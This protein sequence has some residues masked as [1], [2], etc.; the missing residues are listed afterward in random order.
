MPSNIRKIPALVIKNRLAILLIISVASPVFADSPQPAPAKVTV[1]SSTK[2]LCVLSD[3]ASNTTVVSQ[4]VPKGRTW[5]ISGWHRWLFVSDDGESVVIGYGGMNLV[6]IDVTLQEPVLLFYNRGKFM[7]SVTLGDLYTSKS[8]L[9]RTVSH[10]VWAQSL[11]FNKS[12]QLVVELVNG[13]KVAFAAK[14]GMAQ[15]LIRDVGNGT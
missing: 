11:G 10:F 13:K 9:Q 6:P 15:P 14:N 2:N 3:P 1:C 12:D 8:Q 5:T 7:R 4:Q